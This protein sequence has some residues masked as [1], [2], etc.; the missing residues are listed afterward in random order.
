MSR[1]AVVALVVVVLASCVAASAESHRNC[2]QTLYTYK[3]NQRLNYVMNTCSCSL[4]A[5]VI[6]ANYAGSN[7]TVMSLPAWD[8][9]KNT[10]N[11]GTC[12]RTFCRC[13]RALTI[14]ASLH[15]TA[16]AHVRFGLHLLRRKPSLWRGGMRVVVRLLRALLRLEKLT[17]GSPLALANKPKC[18]PS[19]RFCVAAFPNFGTSTYTVL[20][21]CNVDVA[22]TFARG[23]PT[24]SR[25]PLTLLSSL[26]QCKCCSALAT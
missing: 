7:T 21:Q 24:I 25:L 6:T 11:I 10:R 23:I 2:L 4:K 14:D 18:M 17:R 20:N 16:P 19:L 8:G 15:S 9:S 1:I 5:Q 22:G 12:W 26:V 3:S 13:Y